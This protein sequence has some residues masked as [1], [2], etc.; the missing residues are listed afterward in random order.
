[1]DGG[2]SVLVVALS[3]LNLGD[4]H[5][6]IERIVGIGL[7]QGFIFFQSFVELVVA[8]QCLRQRIHGLRVAWLHIFCALVSGDRVFWL[9]QLLIERAQ[10]KFHLRRAAFL[11]NR[12]NRR[13]CL[14]HVPALGIKPRQVQYH[15]FRL[16]FNGLRDLELGFGLV[17]LVLHSVELSQHHVI[18]HA[19]GLQGHDFLE[20]GNRLIEHIR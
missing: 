2:Q 5:Q 19:L 20:F 13:H 7:G 14:A 12:C 3:P 8:Q 10:R 15:L 4:M 6:R 17:G 1:M 16:W 18:F 11:R 9:L